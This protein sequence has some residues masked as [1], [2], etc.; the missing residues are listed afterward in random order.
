VRCSGPARRIA[1]DGAVARTTPSAGQG[2]D[3]VSVVAMDGGSGGVS[4]MAEPNAGEQGRQGIRRKASK[5]SAGLADSP[6][7][8]KPNVQVRAIPENPTMGVSSS[9]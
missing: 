2:L 9:K 7:S 8:D 6:F 3:G 5:N 1:N 4:P